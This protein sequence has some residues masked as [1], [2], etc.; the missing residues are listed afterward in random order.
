MTYVIMSLVMCIVYIMMS[1]TV[2]VWSHLYHDALPQISLN[3]AA[4]QHLWHFSLS[5]DYL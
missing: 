2:T 3:V 4:R 5:P 1:V